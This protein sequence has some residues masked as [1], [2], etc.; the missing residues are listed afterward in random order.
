[1]PMVEHLSPCLIGIGSGLIGSRMLLFFIKLAHHCQRGTAQSSFFLSWEFGF[2]IG[3]FLTGWL[4][5]YKLLDTIGLVLAI[6]AI[7]VYHFF[8]HPW[9][10][11]HKSR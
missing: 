1:M 4:V 9:Y 7:L 10:M 5:D 3:L 8:T 11:R 6:A 2:A